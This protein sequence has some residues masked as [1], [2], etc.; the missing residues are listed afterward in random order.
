MYPIAKPRGYA[1]QKIKYSLF[2][3]AAAVLLIFAALP[4]ACGAGGAV[5][6]VDAVDAVDADGARNIYVGDIISLEITPRDVSAGEL[7]EIFSDFEI[8]EIKEISGGFFGAGGPSA[9]DGYRISIRTFE[10]GE[11]VARLDGRDIVINVASALDDFKRDGIFE[12]AGE[13]MTESPGFPWYILSAAA[14]AVCAA[15]GGYALIGLI[16]KR[17]A[18]QPDP[19]QLFLAR[20]GALQADDG[21]Y[22]ADLTRHFK[23]YMEAAY[24]RRIIGKTSGEIVGELEGIPSAGP[25]LG[26]INKWLAECDRFKFTGVTADTGVKKAHYAKLVNIAERVD[27]IARAENAVNGGADKNAL[28]EGAA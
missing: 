10:P 22:L 14:A 6:A 2:A 19:F 20:T 24:R 16:R 7:T 8:V 21:G 25:V 18:K 23:D 13:D 4:V 5:G 1:A 26:D 3:Q 15:S 27:A 9:Q 12:G 17:R 11:Y 28:K